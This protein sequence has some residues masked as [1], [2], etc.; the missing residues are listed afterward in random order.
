MRDLK[1][2]YSY[3]LNLNIGNLFKLGETHA[4]SIYKTIGSYFYIYSLNQ[5]RVLRGEK[6]TKEHGSTQC[7]C[8]FPTNKGM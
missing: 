1:L 5:R 8:K 4:I 3:D 7:Q 2:L 6:K